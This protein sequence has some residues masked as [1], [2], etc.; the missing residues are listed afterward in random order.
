MFLTGNGA[1]PVGSKVFPVKNKAFP[2]RNEAFATGNGALPVGSKVFP[3]KNEAFARRNEAF[4]IKKGARG[5]QRH[6]STEGQRNKGVVSDL[7]DTHENNAGSF[8]T[9]RMILVGHPSGYFAPGAMDDF[10]IYSRA[11]TEEQIQEL[12]NLRE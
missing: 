7:Y 8:T 3:V 1:F 6:I 4:G 11:L 2:V 10:R 5:I 12:Y 9:A